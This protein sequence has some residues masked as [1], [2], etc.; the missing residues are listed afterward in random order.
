M[1][2]AADVLNRI[3]LFL[4]R[5]TDAE[6]FSFDFP[7]DLADAYADLERENKALAIMLNDELPDICAAFQPD[8]AAR[9]G[10]PDLLNEDQFRQKVKEVYEK[11]NMMV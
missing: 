8:E 5:D 2:I 7:D 6:E 9:R 3:K 10:E 1:S 11:A 4:D